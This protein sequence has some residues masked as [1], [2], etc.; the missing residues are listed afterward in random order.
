[1]TEPDSGTDI[2]ASKTEAVLS[3]DHYALSGKKCF[4]TNANVA[5]HYVVFARTPKADPKDPLTAFYVPANAAGVSRGKPLEKL[6]HRESDTGEIYF[7]QVKVPVSHRIGR[8][9]EGIKIAFR[10]LHRSKTIL[11]GGAVGTCDRALELARD[12]LSQRVHYGK[13]LITIPT[14]RSMLAQLHTEVEASWLLT[15]LAAATWETGDMA[16]REASQAKMFAGH[17]ASKVTC[18]VLELMG[19]Y[20]F[21][22]ELEIERL[23]RDAKFYEIIE[24]ATFVQQVLISKELFPREAT[25]KAREAA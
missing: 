22:T 12:F 11:A 2:H 24:G 18:E 4:I 9:G 20:G 6:G 25:T 15:C 14:I 1:M 21:T 5:T 3:G 17:T 13:P 8:E 7:D 19:G 10:S 23:Y 16:I